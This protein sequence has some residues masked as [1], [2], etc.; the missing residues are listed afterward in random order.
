MLGE[1]EH[2][3]HVSWK[4][5]PTGHAGHG[6]IVALQT[7]MR[8]HG[9][10]EANLAHFA[11]RAPPL[12]KRLVG[13]RPQPGCAVAY[14]RLCFAYLGA[15]TLQRG[16][17]TLDSFSDALRDDRDLHRLAERFW[18]EDDGNPDPA[19]FVPAEAIA[20]LTDGAIVRVPV[21]QQFGSP[22]WPLSREEH[23]AKARACLAFGGFEPAYEALLPVLDRFETEPDAVQ[24]LRPAFA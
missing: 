15:V 2:V 7:M 3:T 23:C 9:V 11:Y 21:V 19:A 13:R 16:S 8:D 1:V 5:Y 17:V 20:R 4:P 24:A 12:I 14:A 18:V 22:E 10:T 6:A